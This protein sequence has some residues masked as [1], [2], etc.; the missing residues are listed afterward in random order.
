MRFPSN[1]GN[2]VTRFFVWN[3]TE[4]KFLFL[5]LKDVHFVLLIKT[6]RYFLRVLWKHWERWEVLWCRPGIEMSMCCQSFPSQ[7]Q[8][9]PIRREKIKPSC[10]LMARKWIMIKSRICRL[11]YENLDGPKQIPPNLLG[12]KWS[13]WDSKR[14]WTWRTIAQVTLTLL[15]TR[16][17]TD[18]QPV[19]GSQIH[20]WKIIKIVRLCLGFNSREELLFSQCKEGWLWKWL[21]LRVETTISLLWKMIAHCQDSKI[22]NFDQIVSFCR[23]SVRGR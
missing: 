13:D 23:A 14:S 11:E 2:V 1:F 3:T 4:W 12:L 7:T 18:F 22:F 6:L 10:F 16:C 17:F 19:S 5:E 9:N 15:G 8:L 20:W 21:K